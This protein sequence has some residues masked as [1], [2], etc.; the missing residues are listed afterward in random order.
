MYDKAKRLTKFPTARMDVNGDRLRTKRMVVWIGEEV[1]D[2]F[3]E[4]CEDNNY[5]RPRLV[6]LILEEFLDRFGVESL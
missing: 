5:S 2:E 1:Y 6:E 3:G 4:Y